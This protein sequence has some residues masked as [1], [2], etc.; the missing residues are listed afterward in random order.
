MGFSQ[1]RLGGSL[2]RGGDRAGKGDRAQDEKDPQ[3][4]NKGLGV[5]LP[6]GREKL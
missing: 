1:E 6:G 5:R 4:Q 2:G 3:G